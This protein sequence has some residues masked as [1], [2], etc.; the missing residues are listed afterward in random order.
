MPAQDLS[1]VISASVVPVVIISACGLLCLAFYNRLSAIVGRLRSFQ[2]ERLQE[3]DWLARH[4]QDADPTV[5]A[6]HHQLLE[7][8]DVQTVHVT[9]RA[10]LIQRTLMCLL[11]AIGCLII[12][13]LFLGLSILH[14]SM[15]Y[16]A[17]AIFVA[18]LCCVLGA[19][20][21]AVCELMAAL[22]PIELESRFVG[23]LTENVENSG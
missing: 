8:L 9:R 19:V 11:V 4:A 23:D 20:S 22:E 13:S 6:R 12:C 21:F 7:M 10:K 17:A 18:G 3:Q 2:R 14:E 1:K 15:I 16:I 5:M